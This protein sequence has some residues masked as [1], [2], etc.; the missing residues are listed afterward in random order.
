MQFSYDARRHLLDRQAKEI[1]NLRSALSSQAQVLDDR[2]NKENAQVESGELA[3]FA[4]K[5]QSELKRIQQEANNFG[6][7][8]VH[9]RTERDQLVVRH[10]EE[11]GLHQRETNQIR[12]QLRSLKQQLANRKDVASDM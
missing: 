6:R 3:V 10:R 9:L 5:L 12:A 2:W 8:L 4:R 7:D 1:E 11:I